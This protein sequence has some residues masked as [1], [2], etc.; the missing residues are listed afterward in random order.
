MKDGYWVIRTYKSGLVG[1]KIKFFVPGRRPEK[2]RR[3]DKR[4]ASRMEKK[5]TGTV[6]RQLARLLNANCKE[7]FVLIGLDYSEAGMEKILKAARKKGIPVDSQDAEEKMNAIWEA[8]DCELVN[9]IRR[10][11]R[12]LKKQGE[13]FICPCYITS[14]MDG[15]TGETVRVHH[16]LVANLDTLPAFIAAWQEQ[17]L[18]SVDYSKLWGSQKDRTP[19]AEYLIRQVRRIPDAKKYRSTRNIIRPAPR[20]VIAR[21]ASELR[22]PRGSELLFR[23]EFRSGMEQQYIRYTL[24]EAPKK[25]ERWIER[26]EGGGDGA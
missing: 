2:I 13:E 15:E 18:G 24:P 1:E 16:H 19:M 9:A 26:N 23:A 4:E 14:D 21:N 8:A 22:C 6:I 7:G 12:I 25:M 20:D 10:V 5:T 11:K 17:G 3:E